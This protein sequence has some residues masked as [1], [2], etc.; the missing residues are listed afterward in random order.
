[1]EVKKKI[2]QTQALFEVDI[3]VVLSG[4]P[5]EEKAKN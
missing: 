1:M 5:W 4:E 3:K 2:K